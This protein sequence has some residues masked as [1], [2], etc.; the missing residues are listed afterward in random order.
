MLEETRIGSVMAGIVPGI[1]LAVDGGDGD[2]EEKKRRTEQVWEM[3]R[4]LSWRWIRFSSGDAV[5]AWLS[6]H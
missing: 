3:T 4:T 2:G 6:E 5:N 1:R